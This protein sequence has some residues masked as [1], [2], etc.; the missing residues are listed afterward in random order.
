M[1]LSSSVFSD[2][3]RPVLKFVIFVSSQ[4]TVPSST[5]S[6]E[7]CSS[8]IQ[9]LSIFYRFRLIH[10]YQTGLELSDR[11]HASRTSIPMVVHRSRVMCDGCRS[12]GETMFESLDPS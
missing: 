1:H 8:A 7:T 5:C 6:G 4:F 12:P 10:Y 2:Q 3:G 9:S 11:H